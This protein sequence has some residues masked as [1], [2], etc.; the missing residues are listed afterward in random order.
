MADHLH[1]AG[2]DVAHVDVR[3]ADGILDRPYRVI[4]EGDLI[5]DEAG[6]AFLG[7]WVKKLGLAEAVSV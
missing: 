3:P 5:H 2:Y 7:Y 6:A 1:A 4:V